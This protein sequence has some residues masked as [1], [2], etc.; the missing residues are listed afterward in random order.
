MHMQRLLQANKYLFIRASQI[1]QKTWVWPALVD[2]QRPLHKV[3]AFHVSLR[4]FHTPGYFYLL[5]TSL[6]S[7]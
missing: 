4:R 7:I 1:A 3:D 6:K 5:L 2:V